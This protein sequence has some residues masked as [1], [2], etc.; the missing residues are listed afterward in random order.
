MHDPANAVR[1]SLD[2]QVDVIGHQAIGIKEEWKIGLLHRQQ[3][4]ELLIV[5]GRIEYLP[6]IIAASNNVIETTLDFNTC[7]A[8]HWTADASAL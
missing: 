4:E 7:S 5:S 8:G 6:A 1:L 3:R 2:Q